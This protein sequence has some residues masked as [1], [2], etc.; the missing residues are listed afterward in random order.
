MNSLPSINPD[1][2]IRVKAALDA[3]GPDAEFLVKF[4]EALMKVTHGSGFG[5][6]TTYVSGKKVTM[7]RSEETHAFSDTQDYKFEDH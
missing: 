4:V 2:V 5:K 7:I 3:W 1:T 6:I